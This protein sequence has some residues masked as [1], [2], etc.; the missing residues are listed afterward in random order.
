MSEKQPQESNP[1]P[2]VISMPDDKEKVNEEHMYTLFKKGPV[3]PE[4]FAWLPSR[5]FLW[6]LNGFFAKG[7]KKRIGED[8]LYEMLDRN[9]SGV[10][11]GGVLKNWAIEQKKAALKGRPPSLLRALIMTFWSRYYTCIIG[12][13]CG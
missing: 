8:D 2:T 11:A 13:E 6:W 12:M 10:L 7:Y 4:N 3:S 1:D 9:K 5:I